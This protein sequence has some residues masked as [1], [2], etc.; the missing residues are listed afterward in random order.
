MAALSAARER[1]RTLPS[2]T[3]VRCELLRGTA[4]MTVYLLLRDL[5]PPA[6][7]DHAS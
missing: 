6:K 4:R 1:F 2:G 5:V 3:K 7:V